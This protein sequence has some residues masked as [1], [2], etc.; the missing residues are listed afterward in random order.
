MIRDWL[1]EDRRHEA[2]LIQERTLSKGTTCEWEN[3][4]VELQENSLYVSPRNRSIN[5]TPVFGF[6]KRVGCLDI[7]NILS[8]AHPANNPTERTVRRKK[9][10]LRF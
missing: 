6:A 10:S 4:E 9:E 5:L 3:G 8:T 7:R 1:Q 2:H